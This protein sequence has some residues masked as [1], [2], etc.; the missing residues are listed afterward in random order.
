MQERGG[1]PWYRL[2]TREVI[3]GN[4]AWCDE[5]KDWP[6]EGRDGMKCQ[7]TVWKLNGNCVFRYYADVHGSIW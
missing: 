4:A 5:V 3:Q 2:H 7:G 1:Q 6:Q